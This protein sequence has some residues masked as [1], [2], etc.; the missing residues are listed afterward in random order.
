MEKQYETSLE[1]KK[2]DKFFDDLNKMLDDTA[3]FELLVYQDIAN[4]Y[5]YYAQVSTIMSKHITFI[6]KFKDKDNKMKLIRR[7]LYSNNVTKLM[8]RENR[9][10]DFNNLMTKM[11]DDLVNIYREVLKDLS[12]NGLLPNPTKEEVEDTEH[13]RGIAA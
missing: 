9:P 3:K 12:H 10:K 6:E 2:H 7:G 1:W 8:L 11:F 5:Q 4:I 13:K